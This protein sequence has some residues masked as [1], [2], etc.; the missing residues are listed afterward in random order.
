MNGRNYYQTIKKTK[1]ALNVPYSKIADWMGITTGNLTACLAQGLNPTGS[2]WEMFKAGVQNHVGLKNLVRVWV[3][4]KK[5]KLCKCGC[6][7]LFMLGSP[8][9]RK[10]FHRDTCGRRKK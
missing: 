9:S 8:R 2:Q 5:F 1:V 4:E 10:W 6:N 3:E 7:R